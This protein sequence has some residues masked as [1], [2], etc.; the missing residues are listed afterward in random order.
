MR[1]C[2]SHQLQMDKVFHVKPWRVYHCVSGA[3]AGSKSRRRRRHISAVTDKKARV[4]TVAHGLPEPLLAAQV[5]ELEVLF[6]QH[7]YVGDHFAVDAD[8]RCLYLLVLPAAEH[9]GAPDQLLDLQSWQ[10]GCPAQLSRRTRSRA[11]GVRQRSG[12]GEACSM[13]Q[14]AARQRDPAGSSGCRDEHICNIR[15]ELS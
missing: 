11:A 10:S 13:G 1:A 3:R 15:A 14:L 2:T 7:V 8:D 6:H 12:F 5:V 4:R 9:Q